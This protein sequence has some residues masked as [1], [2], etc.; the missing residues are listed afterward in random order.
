MANILFSHNLNVEETSVKVLLP[1][2]SFSVQ[3]L[4]SGL[5]HVEPV[6]S[7]SPTQP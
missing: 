5:M 4:K 7:L 1:P 6:L 3:G 2:F